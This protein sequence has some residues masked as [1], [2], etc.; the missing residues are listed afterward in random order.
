LENPGQVDAAL[1]DA[2][3]YRPLFD[4]VVRTD[5]TDPRASGSSRGPPC[6][7]PIAPEGA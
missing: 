5:D 6:Q 3:A 2:H 7:H 4:T 1:Q